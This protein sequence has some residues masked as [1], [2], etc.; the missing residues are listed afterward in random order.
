MA[1][2]IKALFR[3]IMGLIALTSL[4]QQAFACTCLPPESPTG[5][6]ERSAAVFAGEVASVE[7]RSGLVAS[8]AEPIRVTFPVYTAWKGPQHDTLTVTTA[9]STIS[10]GYPLRPGKRTWSTFGA[11]LT[12]SR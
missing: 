10:C 11:R 1:S 2:R 7:V 9:R 12:I 8:S 5:E 3:L 6:L 4:G